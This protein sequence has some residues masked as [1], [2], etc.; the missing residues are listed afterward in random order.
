MFGSGGE[1]IFAMKIFPEE[2]TNKY[3]S[4][5]CELSLEG[6]YLGLV[7]ESKLQFITD[8]YRC[9]NYPRIILCTVSRTRGT[10]A[11]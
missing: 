5:K 3:H 1:K 8:H 9:I 10:S 6:D 2:T 11:Y 4:V 7:Q